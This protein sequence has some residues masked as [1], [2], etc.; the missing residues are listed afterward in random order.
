MNRAHREAV[1]KVA[2]ELGYKQIEVDE[3]VRWFLSQL[4]DDLMNG[5][6]KSLRLY[7][8]G[9][10][11]KRDKPYV[12]KRY[13]RKENAEDRKEH[14]KHIFLQRRVQTL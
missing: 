9:Y 3:C 11:Y 14:K 10:V 1:R 8:I 4:R 13:K 12:R 6:V 7:T 2:N 5:M